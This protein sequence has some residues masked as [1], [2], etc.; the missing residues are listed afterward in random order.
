MPCLGRVAGVGGAQLTGGRQDAI[1]GRS[2]PHTTPTVFV[3]LRGLSAN[4]PAAQQ[5]LLVSYES[6]TGNV[7]ATPNRV[8]LPPVFV[9]AD[10]A[11]N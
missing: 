10:G 2:A 7:S 1:R 5:G 6:P 9:G 3:A 8:G 4:S 11:P